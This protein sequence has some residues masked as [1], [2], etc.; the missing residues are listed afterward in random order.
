MQE[1]FNYSFKVGVK[2]QPS[3]SKIADAGSNNNSGTL[4][5]SSSNSQSQTVQQTS[6]TYN[7]ADNLFLR[8]DS[9]QPRTSDSQQTQQ[10]DNSEEIDLLDSD[11]DALN[12]VA[13][14][15]DNPKQ[16]SS[17]SKSDEQAKQAES[18]HQPHQPPYP[19]QPQQDEEIDLLDSDEDALNEVA[20]NFNY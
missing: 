8:E 19:Q 12:E 9:Q 13:A 16:D 17:K 15:F 7:D 3:S 6:S 10:P 4:A 11:E 2:E 20:A 18:Q 1:A 14:N 5:P